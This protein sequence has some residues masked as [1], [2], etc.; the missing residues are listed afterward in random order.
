MSLV[1]GGVDDFG[2]RPGNGPSGYD[3]DDYSSQPDGTADDHE[4]SFHPLLVA[5]ITIPSTGPRTWRPP[6]PR[7]PGGDGLSEHGPPPGLADTG[8]LR[9]PQDPRPSTRRQAGS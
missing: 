6:H 4:T 2:H 3:G 9:P 1:L 8:Q 7:D 5:N